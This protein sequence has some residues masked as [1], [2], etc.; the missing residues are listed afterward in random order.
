MAG[1][2]ADRAGFGQRSDGTQSDGVDLAVP[3]G[4][5]VL[6]AEAGTIAYAGSEV[7]TYGNLVLIRHDNGL[8]TAYAHTT[9]SWCS[10]ATG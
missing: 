5:E 7:K 9:R 6:A 8:V 2:R 10:A 3:V 4:T 1:P